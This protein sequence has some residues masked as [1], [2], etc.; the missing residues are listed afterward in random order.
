MFQIIYTTYISNIPFSSTMESERKWKIYKHNRITNF[1][2][3]VSYKYIVEDYVNH[4]IY[5]NLLF[6]NKCTILSTVC[7]IW[8][9][10]NNCHGLNMQITPI[11]ITWKL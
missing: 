8:L 3:Y 1:P 7:G 4:V 2:K 11:H 9:K 5:R 10:T 6:I